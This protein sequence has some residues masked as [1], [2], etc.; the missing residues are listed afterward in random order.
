MVLTLLSI[1]SKYINRRYRIPGIV[2]AAFHLCSM[3]HVGIDVDV[4]VKASWTSDMCCM[5]S[6]IKITSVKCLC[7]AR[8]KV[9]FTSS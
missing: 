2:D 1:K 3:F 8:F 5:S 9:G 6:S 7:C 4:D